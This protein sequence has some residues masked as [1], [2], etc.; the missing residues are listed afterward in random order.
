M[1]MRKSNSEGP[2]KGKGGLFF[3][4]SKKFLSK[5]NSVIFELT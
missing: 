3:R 1:T 5:K 4:S 2:K